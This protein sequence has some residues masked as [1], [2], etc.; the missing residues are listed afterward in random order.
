MSD[1][2]IAT[3]R[4]STPQGS[5][6]LIASQI[7]LGLGVFAL[8]IAVLVGDVPAW[9]TLWFLF[10]W[11]GWLLVLD[12][13]ILRAQGHSFLVGRRRELGAMLFWSVP[14][15]CVFEAYNLRLENWYYV[16]LPHSE[17]VQ[18]AF[19]WIAFATVLPACFFHAELLKSWG[20]WEATRWRPLP[21]TRGVEAALALFGVACVVL[22]LVSPTYAFWMVWGVTLGVPE[23]INRRL[24]V[25]SLLADLERGEPA[26]VLRL[27]AGGLMAGG[28]WEGLNYWARAKWI[29]TVPGFESY[30]LF[31]M[32]WLGF[33]GFP[34]LALEAFAGYAL[35]CHLARGG[36]HWERRDVDQPPVRSW[37]RRWAMALIVGFSGATNW[38]TLDP[39]VQARRPLLSAM[40]LPDEVAALE[41]IGVRSPEHLVGAV[42][43]MGLGETA[44]TSTVTE[45]RLARAYEL[46]DLALHKG[47]G[48]VVARRLWAL[49]YRAAADLGA[50]EPD[51][52]WQ[53]LR[54]QD[55]QKA[56]RIAQVRVWVRAA[57]VSNSRR[58]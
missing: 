13:L 55:P 23:V 29:Y 31:E 54:R 57:R 30:K 32:P 34:V 8:G 49:G 44:L 26:R 21:V 41:E 9:N 19:A 38:F 1:L 18:A 15:W 3:S 47:M 6:S 7:P 37:H 58:R 33:V 16:F 36:R 46:S 5:S 51:E 28:V 56:P 52:L 35:L 11:V 12:G 40:L 42:E 17:W 2:A 25:P 53:Q 48:D 22:P 24:G 4:A 39:I 10:G 27:L 20:W 45:S 50:V 43:A 14:Y